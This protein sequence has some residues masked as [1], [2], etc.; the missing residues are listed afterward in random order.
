M[1]E[2]WYLETENIRRKVDLKIP[3]MKKSANEY[4]DIIKNVAKEE[5]VNYGLEK[6][7][8][9]ESYKISGTKNTIVHNHN[10]P[11]M[12]KIFKDLFPNGLSTQVNLLQMLWVVLV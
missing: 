7:T 4:A 2:Q 1:L 3:G 5:L 9:T 12:N 8:G 6:I 11:L 10:I